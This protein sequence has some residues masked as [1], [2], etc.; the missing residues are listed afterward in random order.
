MHDHDST[1]R[2]IERKPVYDASPWVRLYRE[3]VELPSGRILDDYYHVRLPDFCVI[4]ATTTRREFV[5][6]RGYKH[7]IGRVNL[8]PPAGMIDD[9][10]NALECAQRELLEETGFAAKNWKQVGKYVTDGNR[11]C[12]TMYLFL[13]TE[14][15][16]EQSP[17]ADEAEPLRH[18]LVDADQLWQSLL[19]GE[20]GNLAGVTGAAMGLLLGGFTPPAMCRGQS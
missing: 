12:G 13:A 4:I 15:K 14:A 11:H 6:V 20:I 19:Q 2:T 9:G 16:Q 10:E 1:W 17:H 7:G 5:M 3:S 18:E 8:S